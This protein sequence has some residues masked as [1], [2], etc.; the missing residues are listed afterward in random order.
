MYTGILHTHTLVVTLYLIFLL[1][2]TILLLAGKKEALNK[3]RSKTK[4]VEMVLATLFLLTG[5]YLAFQAA[6]VSS[7]WFIVK[8]VL[9]V[10]ILAFGV[11][12]FKRESKFL[13][14]LTFV[15]F[16]YTYGISETKSLTFQKD[17]Q[18]LYGSKEVSEKQ[19]NPGS[20][21]YDMQA[22]GK[23]VYTQNCVGCHGPKGKGR[24]SGSKNLH[25]SE[26]S[27]DEK[28]QVIKK[29]KKTMPAYKSIL[30]KAE[31]KA[32]AEY[33]DQFGN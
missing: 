25:K 15:I 22:H 23:Y 18:K 33:V 7:A 30:S 27:L 19:W 4:V 24:K 2:K 14:L 21:D 16:L 20:S 1:I 8:L 6:S 28:M 32:V 5:I 9:I 3:F 11:I 31:V 17:V 10:A 12:A 13:A 26:L 29:G